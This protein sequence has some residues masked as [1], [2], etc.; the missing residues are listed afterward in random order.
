LFGIGVFLKGCEDIVV[1]SLQDWGIK[2]DFSPNEQVRRQA[3][4]GRVVA[5]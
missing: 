4:D 1:N 3:A 2:A 5:E